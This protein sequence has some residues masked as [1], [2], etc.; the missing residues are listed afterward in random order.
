MIA[1]LETSRGRP[2]AAP[3]ATIAA[4]NVGPM[5]KTALATIGERV[6]LSNTDSAGK[7]ITADHFQAEQ[8]VSARLHGTL[9]ASRS[10]AVS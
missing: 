5:T 9:C 3:S 6:W 1:P 2:H 10:I 4:V 7:N 8:V